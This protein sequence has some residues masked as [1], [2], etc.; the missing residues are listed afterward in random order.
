MADAPPPPP[1]PHGHSPRP[2]GGLPD[3]NYDIF[4]IPPHSAGSGFLYNDIV[5]FDYRHMLL[6]FHMPEEEARRNF[7]RAGDKAELE[8]ILGLEGVREPTQVQVVEVVM[9]AMDVPWRLATQIA[10]RGPEAVR[11]MEEAG[12]KVRQLQKVEG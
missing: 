2:P 6:F 7:H 10:T 12:F 8:G 1:P 11:E 9:E 4:I 5:P 3:G